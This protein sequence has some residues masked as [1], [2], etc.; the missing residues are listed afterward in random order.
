MK[1]R[2]IRQWRNYFVNER[3]DLPED[4]ARALVS[5][6]FAVPE[7]PAPVPSSPGGG[8]PR[9]GGG[10]SAPPAP[11]PKSVTVRVGPES[12]VEISLWPPRPR[13]EEEWKR[14]A[15]VTVRKLGRE[16]G[17]VQVREVLHLT[18]STALAVGAV[19]LQWGVE[20]KVLD[21][22]VEE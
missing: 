8:D 22:E 14:R 17:A 12:W 5:S 11:A 13:A 20:G 2:F 10:V 21:R 4:E 16:N 3:A 6:G 7:E 15:G 1:V 19:L 9:V 18:P